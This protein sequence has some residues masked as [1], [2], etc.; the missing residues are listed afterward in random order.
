MSC[1]AVA[2]RGTL[3]PMSE[4]LRSIDLHRTGRGR[5]RASNGR[6]GVLDV[7]SGADS[8]FTPVELLLTAIASC[9]AVD[10]DLI[11]S[12]RADPLTFRV[13]AAGE[14]VR[15]E[16]GNH[17]TDLRVTFDV[18]F[19]AGEEGD[20]ARDVLPRTLDQTRDR[21]CTVSRTVAIGTPVSYALEAS[22]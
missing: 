21:L 5:Y 6:G 20:A 15:D 11:T 13:H 10:V 14:K 1:G 12:R 18:T 7:G 8:D 4:G 3:L 9:S 17:L 19:P 22:T 2:G 16:R